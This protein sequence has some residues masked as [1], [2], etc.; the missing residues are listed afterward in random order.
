MREELSGNTMLQTCN[1]N[2]SN[3]GLKTGHHDRFPELFKQR[4]E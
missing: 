3:L 1:E 2:V 4:A